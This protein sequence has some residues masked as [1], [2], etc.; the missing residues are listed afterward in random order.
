[1]VEPSRFGF[2]WR[3]IWADFKQSRGWKIVT[4]S[5]ALAGL[6]AFLMA[7]FTTWTPALL[8]ASWSGKAKVILLLAFLC[9]GLILVLIAVVDGARRIH[10]QRTAP[11][12]ATIESQVWLVELAE[13]DRRAIS[14]GVRVTGCE[15]DIDIDLRSMRGWVEFRFKIFNGSVFP[16]ALADVGG[17]VSFSN[18]S[19]FRKLDG[20]CKVLPNLSAGNCQRHNT[21]HFTLHHDLSKEDVAF[22][23]AARSGCFMFDQLIIS[24]RG[25][26]EAFDDLP[27]MSLAT[28]A[29]DVQPTLRGAFRHDAT[30]LEAIRKSHI[31]RMKA[32]SV[33]QGMYEKA[34]SQLQRTEASIEGWAIK[35]WELDTLMV[36]DRGYKDRVLSEQIYQRICRRHAVPETADEQERWLGNCIQRLLPLIEEEAEYIK[37]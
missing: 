9:V 20:E 14:N 8:L 1:M 16:I 25:Q 29:D 21:G 4:I 5:Y 3:A 37:L 15:V 26:G 13:R 32:L 10:L 24:V 19:E 28:K 31:S 36:L 23:S 22:I 18:M 30:A 17:L 12:N 35:D 33:V 27:A 34:H 11:L 2:F 7:F 6:I